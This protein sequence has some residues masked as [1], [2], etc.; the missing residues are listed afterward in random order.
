MITQDAPINPRTC[1][2]NAS[3]KENTIKTTGIQ[4]NQFTN[5]RWSGTNN[6]VAA[7]TVVTI[8]ADVRGAFHPPPAASLSHDQQ[9]HPVDIANAV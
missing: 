5:T 6:T 7:D 2:F 1:I 3:G 4:I 8:P 9:R